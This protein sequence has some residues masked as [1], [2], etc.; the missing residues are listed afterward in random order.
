MDRA[1]RCD[2]CKWWDPREFPEE[3]GRVQLGFCR[4]HSPFLVNGISKE[5]FL[6]NCS[7]PP[8][9]A[10]TAD[11]EGA[12]GAVW[13]YTRDWDFCGEFTPMDSPVPLVPP[14]CPLG[15]L[16]GGRPIVSKRGP[17]DL[18]VRLDGAGGATTA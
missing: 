5:L 13:P 18:E 15:E 16:L 9:D 2:R 3:E 6:S 11:Y 4:R 8:Y 7:V 14:G 10:E 1:E 12:G 17:F